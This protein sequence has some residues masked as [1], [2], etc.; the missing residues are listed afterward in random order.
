[1]AAR[2]A[3]AARQAR[4]A[5]SGDVVGRVPDRH[6]RV[7][8]ELVDRAALGMD[9]L[10]GQRQE[11]GQMRLDVRAELFGEFGKARQVG[12]QHGDF[13]ELAARFRLEPS[14]DQRPHDFER[15]IFGEGRQP[16]GH[17]LQRLREIVEFGEEGRHVAHLVE[18]KIARHRATAPPAAGAAAQTEGWRTALRSRRRAAPARRR[19][20][21]RVSVL[22]SISPAKAERGIAVSSRQSSNGK[23]KDE[24]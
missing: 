20:R 19:R 6:H 4:K 15:H 5:W 1:M 11:A 13:R 9:R 10:D 14:V 2:I 18:L 12:E 22:R 23:A 8:D 7:A 17:A 3:A 21:A 16:A 24:T